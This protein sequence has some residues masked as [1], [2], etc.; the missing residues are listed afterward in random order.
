MLPPVAGNSKSELLA[1]LLVGRVGS[2][3]VGIKRVLPAPIVR[4]LADSDSPALIVTVAELA[5]LMVTVS[6][7]VGTVPVLQLAPV[8]Q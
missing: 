3:P 4:L 7:E 5:G 2:P 8:S 1:E 6:D